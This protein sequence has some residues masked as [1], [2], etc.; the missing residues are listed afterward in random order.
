MMKLMP[1]LMVA[2]ATQKPMQTAMSMG[3]LSLSLLAAL[4]AAMPWGVMLT[5]VSSCGDLRTQ[6]AGNRST[7]IV[8]AGE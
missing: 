6:G 5:T 8:E 2:E 1:A 3:R 4:A 7:L